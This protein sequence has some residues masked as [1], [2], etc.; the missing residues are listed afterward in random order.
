MHIRYLYLIAL[1]F[2]FHCCV[3]ECGIGTNLCD[4][5]L[6]MPWTK[7]FEHDCELPKKR[8]TLRCCGNM[9]KMECLKV[10]NMTEEDLIIK[11]LCTPRC[12]N[13]ILDSGKCKCHTG[14]SGNCCG[15]YIIL[16]D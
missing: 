4:I 15:K 12:V 9:H 13:G 3:N 6:K 1:W 16:K 8:Y 5:T 11:K 14:Y 7:C 2:P 10:C